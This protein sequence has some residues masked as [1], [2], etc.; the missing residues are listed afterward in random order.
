MVC[1]FLVYTASV[2][3]FI[4]DPN[5][6]CGYYRSENG[7]CCC[8]GARKTLRVHLPGG[9][10]FLHEMTSWLPSWNYDIIP[11]SVNRCI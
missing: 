10:T 5:S 11:D 9:A 7:G 1:H 8:T 4:I 6:E 3:S 2:D